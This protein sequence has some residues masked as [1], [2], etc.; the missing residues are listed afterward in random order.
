MGATTDMVAVEGGDVGEDFGRWGGS[1]GWVERGCVGKDTAPMVSGDGVAEIGR[2]DSGCVEGPV[3]WGVGGEDS[4]KMGAGEWAGKENCAAK[5]V[6]GGEVGNGEEDRTQPR[7][8]FRW[9]AVRA[10][11]IKAGDGR[12]L[13]EKFGADCIGERG[14]GKGG[15]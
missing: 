12:L 2:V 15:E 7:I 6:R 3:G 11:P 1:D 4:G 8:G 14:G 10:E 9:R 13:G 5:L